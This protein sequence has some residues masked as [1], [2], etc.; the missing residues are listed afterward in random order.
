MTMKHFILSAFVLLLASPA[1]AVEP[2][3]SEPLLG[4]NQ[5]IT[6]E[7]PAQQVAPAQGK[8]TIDPNRSVEENALLLCHAQDMML[9]VNGPNYVPGV[10]AYGRP[11]ASAD[12]GSGVSIDVPERIEMPVNINVVQALG[13]NI[14]PSPILEANVGTIAILKDGRVLYN[15]QDISSKMNT[16]CADKPQ[17]NVNMNA[18]PQ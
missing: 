16:Y 6:G 2:V 12:G 14:Q 9:T 4:A 1:W 17:L 13:L 18:K 15:N 10:D 11:V 5:V 7:G 3:T 8:P